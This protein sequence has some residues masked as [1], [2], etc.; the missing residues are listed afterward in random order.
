MEIRLCPQCRQARGEAATCPECRSS[1]ILVD[2]EHFLGQSFGKYRLESVVGAGGMGVV[3]RAVHADLGKAVALKMLVPEGRHGDF[4]R[5]FRHEAKVLAALKHP[6]IVEVFDLDVAECGLPYYVMQLLEGQSL[7]AHLAGF[8][9]G[10]PDAEF[11]RFV[12]QVGSALA[13]T[14]GRGI[15]HRDLKPEN[16][17]VEQVDG[18]AVLKVLDFGIAKMVAPDAQASTLTQTGLI[19]GTPHYM[20]PEQLTGVEMGP[21][22]DQYAFALICWEMLTGRAARQGKTVGEIISQEVRK[23]LALEA[24]PSGELQARF[25]PVLA[26]ATDPEPRNRYPSVHA[27][28]DA[29]AGD[30]AMETGKT[31]ISGTAGAPRSPART[32]PEATASRRRRAWWALLALPAAVLAVWAVLHFRH[33]GGPDPGPAEELL[34]PIDSCSVPPDAEA[35][36]DSTAGIV[37]RG[38]GALQLIDPANPAVPARFALE[39]GETFADD[40]AHGLIGIQKDHTLIFVDLAENKR[41]ERIRVGGG[42]WKVV[43]VSPFGDRWAEAWDHGVT[44]LCPS[45]VGPDRTKSIPCPFSANATFQLGERVLAS[46]DDGSL[47]VWDLATLKPLIRTAVPTKGIGPLALIE[48]AGLAAVGGWFDEVFVADYRSGR[49]ETLSLPGQT[50]SLR[51]IADAP[52]LLIAKGDAVHLWRPAAGVVAAF[53]SPG[54]SFADARLTGSGLLAL[55]TAGHRLHRLAYPG[56]AVRGRVATGGSE[57]WALAATEDGGT[58]FAGGADGKLYAV[59][60]ATGAVKTHELHTQGITALLCRDNVLASASDDKTIALR[61]LPSMEVFWRSTAHDYLINALFFSPASGTLWSS[62]SDG[63]LKS[64]RWPQLAEAGEIATGAKSHA[65]LW[66][67][68]DETLVLAGTWDRQLAVL[69]KAAGAWRAAQVYRLPCQAVYAMA[70]VPAAGAVLMTGTQPGILFLYDLRARTLHRLPDLGL[71]ACWAV[72]AGEHEALVAGAGGLLRVTVRRTGAGLSA[73]FAL[74]ANP[75][76][77]ILAAACLLPD[78]TL[79]LGNSAGEVLLVDRAAVP[80]KDLA[81][82]DPDAPIAPALAGADLPYPPAP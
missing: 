8:P 4:V 40:I 51:F 81:T 36:L 68:A 56:F 53:R 35:I 10:L 79:A 12:R 66:V 74:A 33:A 49:V 16:I 63:K 70:A 22:T 30:E 43:A 71:D 23:P 62:S 50:F 44:I 55:D 2:P 58:L 45:G 21:N 19:L 5:R 27:F 20:A 67:N 60:P 37:L 31:W 1:I 29:L 42:P 59:D 77:G 76:A 41:R 15:V 39:P 57:L 6:N 82:L 73:S 64:W 13:Y 72:A 14:H 75:R 54:A 38:I 52:S 7:R 78:G 3:Y 26:R 61:K 80:F 11:Q 17:F 18:R 47:I 69:E 25:G 9:Q 34:A 65:A 28:V 48:E 46:V 24:L 32:A